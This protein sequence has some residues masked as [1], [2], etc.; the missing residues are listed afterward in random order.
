LHNTP[1][2]IA[3]EV[4]QLARRLVADTPGVSVAVAYA[5]CGTYGAL[6]T[7][8]DRLGLVR[9]PGL[10]C[11]DVIA[12][13][14]VVRRL[15]E[16]EPGT[17]LLTDFLVQGF[18]HLVVAELGLDRHPELTADYF[19][20]YRR[21]VWLSEEPR[22][23]IRRKAAAAAARIGLPLVEVPVGVGEIERALID[24]VARARCAESRHT[25]PA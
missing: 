1:Q 21:A 16:E 22:V 2:A 8:C 5:D 4:E 24:L 17:Y 12:G 18:D 10:H 7:V 20:H 15:L 11:Y 6:D 23:A 9:L 3:G 19:G 14:D 25:L 13:A